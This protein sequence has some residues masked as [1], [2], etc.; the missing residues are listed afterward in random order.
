MKHPGLI[1]YFTIAALIFAGFIYLGTTGGVLR[2]V[3]YWL[4][5]GTLAFCHCRNEDGIS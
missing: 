1:V 2:R 5:R 4:G 3:R